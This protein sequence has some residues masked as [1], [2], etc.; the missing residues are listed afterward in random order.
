MYVEDH[1]TGVVVDGGIGV[2]SA[3]V[4]KVD[5]GGDGFL[6]ALFLCGGEGVKGV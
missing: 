6:G 5:E 3:V 2:G 4:E 1:V